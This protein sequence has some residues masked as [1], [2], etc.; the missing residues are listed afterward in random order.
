M[1]DEQPPGSWRLFKKAVA[2]VQSEEKQRRASRSRSGVPYPRLL[3]TAL[4]QAAGIRAVRRQAVL[5]VRRSHGLGVANPP[6]CADEETGKNAVKNRES[7]PHGMLPAGDAMK[8]HGNAVQEVAP[9]EAGDYLET[10]TGAAAAGHCNVL[11]P[12][13]ASCV[14]ESAG[15]GSGFIA[16]AGRPEAGQAIPGGQDSPGVDPSEQAGQDSPGVDP[17]EQAKNRAF[18]EELFKSWAEEFGL[19]L[20]STS[21]PASSPP[22]PP[23]PLELREPT[24]PP[25]S[26]PPPP[27]VKILTVRNSD[28][29]Q[30][31]FEAWRQRG[32][33][34]VLVDVPED[35]PL[36]DLQIIWDMLCQASLNIF[37]NPINIAQRL[38]IG[39]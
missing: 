35:V 3:S 37:L 7:E 8:K 28:D 21:P 39:K 4:R 9:R 16:G 25:P 27:L 30:A 13:A 15:H 22:P 33:D 18:A 14:G 10:H 34:G 12:A 20:P 5:N 11:A 36:L 29:A 31:A 2:A 24:P 26:F 17:S 32:R 1:A 38:S 6:P 19:R 23:P